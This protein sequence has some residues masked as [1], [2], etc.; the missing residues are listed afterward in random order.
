MKLPILMHDVFPIYCVEHVA[1]LEEIKEEGLSY[2]ITKDGIYKK[3]VNPLFTAVTKEGTPHNTETI[4]NENDTIFPC[5]I[6]NCSKIP[7]VVHNLILDFFIKI[8]DKYK[9]EAMIFLLYNPKK[10]EWKIDTPTQDVSAASCS[11]GSPSYHEGYILAG[12]IHSHGNMGAFHSSIDD[13]DEFN[14]NG[15]HITFGNVNTN[16]T[17]AVS[18]VSNGVRFKLEIEDI[19]EGIEP[20]TESEMLTE[21][22]TKV[23]KKAITPYSYNKPKSS[24]AGNNT[25]Q[26][27][28]K[29][30]GLQTWNPQPL[31]SIEEEEEYEYNWD[32]FDKSF[33]PL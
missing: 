26:K 21:M 17:Y 33:K 2:I 24:Y 12:T 22:L 11:Y 25:H 5:Y 9:S 16:V 27:Q 1:Q 20:I 29:K 6:I 8:Y 28:K 18:I 13:T 4:T 7:R 30:S 10:K 31:D 14:Q 23:Q 32:E 3:N 15:I 19:V